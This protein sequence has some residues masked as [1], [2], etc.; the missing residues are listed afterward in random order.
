MGFK[1][2]LASAS[3]WVLLIFIQCCLSG[4]IC[5][6]EILK[7]FEER[8]NISTREK[9]LNFSAVYAVQWSVYI[10]DQYDTIKK[11]GSFE[12]WYEHP[13]DP[14]FDKDNLDYNLFMHTWV[15]QYYYLFYRSR[16]Y[17]KQDSLIY[18]FLSS[19]TFEFTIETTTQQPSIQDCYQT[20]VFGAVLGYWT[21]K[22]SHYLL[23]FGTVAGD[24]IAFLVNPFL[25][26]P[27]TPDFVFSFSPTNDGVV[28]VGVWRF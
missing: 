18:S 11:Y 16:G 4:S 14:H 26:L 19:L 17:L 21:E 28:M 20:P 25:I 23:G 6:A 3:R 13:S 9:I 15:G 1:N 2:K 7:P 22:F 12:N 5:T 10:I 27:P 24:T 8:S